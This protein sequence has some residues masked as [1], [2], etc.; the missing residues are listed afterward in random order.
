MYFRAKPTENCRIACHPVELKCFRYGVNAA[1]RHIS[2]YPQFARGV[3]ILGDGDSNHGI[4]VATAPPSLGRIGAQGRDSCEIRPAQV[5]RA[6][7]INRSTNIPIQ[8]IAERTL[9]IS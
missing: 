1:F 5:Q 2:S 3:C 9:S 6:L 7:Y 8:S 4:D